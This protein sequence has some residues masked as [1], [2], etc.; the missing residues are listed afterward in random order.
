MLMNMIWLVII[1]NNLKLSQYSGIDLTGRVEPSA[2][3]NIST[4]YEMCFLNQAQ[5]HTHTHTHTHH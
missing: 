1:Q 3:P 2:Y 4:I 5:T